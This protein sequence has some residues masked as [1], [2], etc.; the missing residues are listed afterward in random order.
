MA[1]FLSFSEMKLLG[2][3]LNIFRFLVW[4][5]KLYSKGFD[6]WN[7]WRWVSVHSA[8]VSPAL[9]SILFFNSLLFSFWVFCGYLFIF[10]LILETRPHYAAKALLP[11]V[12]NAPALI[13]WVLGLLKCGFHAWLLCSLYQKFHKQGKERLSFKGRG[14][15][16]SV[17]LWRRDQQQAMTVT[18]DLYNWN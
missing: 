15:R 17:C 16:W 2:Q 1:Y 9:R 3:R 12:S 6:K 4:I 10:V 8:A 11:L 7:L 13:S 5:P 18:V 14:W